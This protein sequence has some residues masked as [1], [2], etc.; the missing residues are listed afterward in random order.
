LDSQAYINTLKT[1]KKIMVEF[2][3]FD[4]IWAKINNL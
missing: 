4:E 3:G 1:S 2:V